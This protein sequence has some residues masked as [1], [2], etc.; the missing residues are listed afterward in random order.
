MLFKSVPLKTSTFKATENSRDRAEEI[1]QQK[2]LTIPYFYN[3]RQKPGGS[4]IMA[5]LPW[6]SLRHEISMTGL[7]LEKMITDQ[8]LWRPRVVRVLI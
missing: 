1:S 4:S 2:L 3:L 8:L 6:D 5:V 7:A